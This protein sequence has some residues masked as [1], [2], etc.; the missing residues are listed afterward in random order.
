MYAGVSGYYLKEYC[1]YF[2]SEDLFDLNSVN[3]DEMA[4]DTA[5]HLGLHCF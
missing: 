2:V 1:I 5:F 3:P 4:H